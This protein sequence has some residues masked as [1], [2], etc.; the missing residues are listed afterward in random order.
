MPLFAIVILVIGV[1]ALFFYLP[2]YSRYR[3]LKTESQKLEKELADLR[4]QITALQRE[5]QLLRTD[6]DYVESVIRKELGLVE[7]GEVVYEFDKKKR[8]VPQAP[9]STSAASRT[10]ANGSQASD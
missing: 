1:A 3:E 5:K 8:A 9:K 4:N 2:S 10:T 7:P 6:K